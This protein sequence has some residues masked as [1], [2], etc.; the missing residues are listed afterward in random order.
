MHFIDVTCSQPA[1]KLTAARHQAPS[2]P[3]EG[4]SL[5]RELLGGINPSQTLQFQ[6]MGSF[7]GVVQSKC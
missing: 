7:F 6:V 1:P 3:E 4:A 2:T 5:C